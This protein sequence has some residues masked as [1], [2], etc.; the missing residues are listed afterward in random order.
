MKV[1]SNESLE[2]LCRQ[3]LTSSSGGSKRPRSLLLCSNHGECDCGTCY[4]FPGYQGPYCECPECGD[5]CDPLLA[6]CVCGNCQCK[7]GWSKEN[8]CRKCLDDGSTEGCVAPNG[9]VC[10]GRGQCECGECK[11]FPETRGKFCEINSNTENKLCAFYEPCV[12]CLIE[13]QEN[14][15]KYCGEEEEIL[16]EEEEAKLKEVTSDLKEEEI[17]KD[18][19]INELEAI[20]ITEEREEREENKAKMEREEGKMC[21]YKKGE[22]IEKFKISYIEKDFE[23]KQ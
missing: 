12:I 10:S 15:I 9:E 8:R 1:F 11:C 20:E 4:C 17:L 7:Y 13:R 23:G 16:K 5:D 21:A 22:T 18:K 6:D 14:G 3:P 19:V 2:D